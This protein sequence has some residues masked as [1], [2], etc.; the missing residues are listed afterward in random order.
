MAAATPTRAGVTGCRDFTHVR[1]IMPRGL[2]GKTSWW[3]WPALL[4]W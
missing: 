2:R 1:W 3:G 4:F